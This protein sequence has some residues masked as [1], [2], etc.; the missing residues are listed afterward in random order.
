[1]LEVNV[2]EK[3]IKKQ[4]R[5][6]KKSLDYKNPYVDGDRKIESIENFLQDLMSYLFQKPILE[7]KTR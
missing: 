7:K 6:L 3:T 2:D 5:Y 4:M 1:M